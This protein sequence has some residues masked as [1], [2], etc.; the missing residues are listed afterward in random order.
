ML[1]MAVSVVAPSRDGP[2][3]PLDRPPTISVVIPV[4]QGADLIGEA[5]ESALTQ[6]VAPYEVVVCD[7]GSTDDLT[8][9]LIPFGD[10]VTVL[11]QEHKGVAAARNLGIF[12]ARGEFVAICDADDVLLPRYIEEM[13][14]LAMA[15]PDLDILSRTCYVERDGRIVSLTRTPEDLRFPVDDQRIGILLFNFP[16][17]SSVFR[18]QRLVDLGGYDE[19]L[20]AAEDYDSWLRLILSGSRAGLIRDPL[21]L[22]RE[23]A[24]S[25]SSNVRW[26]MEGEIAALS[27]A[28]A[29]GTLSEAE[30]G[31][32]H[33]HLRADRQVLAHFQ[34]RSA[35]LEGRPG[36]RAQSLRLAV[37]GGQPVRVR[38]KAA[39][40][41][42][43]PKFVVRRS[44]PEPIADVGP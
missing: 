7:D 22:R 19:T 11:H 20:R 23:R 8:G 33:A 44:R 41:A 34:A 6:T 10:R 9:A 12:H 1:N 13:G 15:R 31:V 17:G 3:A 30:Q 40:A 14:S 4:Y 2:V 18:R 42:L 27:K 5:V 32:A 16:M 21:A 28:L 35:I 36:A 29:A 24:G 25:L 43:L 39:I 38:I 37:S 26:C